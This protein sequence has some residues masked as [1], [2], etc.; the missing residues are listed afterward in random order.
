MASLYQSS[1]FGLLLNPFGRTVRAVELDGHHLTFT[2][3]GRTTS[4]SLASVTSAPILRKRV[5]VILQPEESARQLV[6]VPP[7]VPDL[8]EKNQSWFGIGFPS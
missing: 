3:R 4:V 8:D 5:F 2:K 1:L 7:L 6:W